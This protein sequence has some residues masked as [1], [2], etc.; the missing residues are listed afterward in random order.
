MNNFAARDNFASLVIETAGIGKMSHVILCDG[1]ISL[2]RDLVL[3]GTVNL[4][5]CFVSSS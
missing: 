2:M 1:S 5:N 3:V 4:M